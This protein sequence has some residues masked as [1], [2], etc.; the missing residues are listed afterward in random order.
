MVDEPRLR[1]GRGLAALIGESA[2]DS[3]DRDKANAQRRL[4]IEFVRRNPQNPRRD[5][6]E[7]ELEDLAASI[8]EKGILQ[9]IVVRHLNNAPGIYEIIAGERRWR[10]AQ[11]ASMHTIPVVV[12]D[13]TD[14]EALE[15]AIIENVQRADLN[16]LEESEAYA[17][18]IANHNYTQADLAR[19]I[20]KSRSHVANTLRLASLS[21]EIKQ[22][23][24]DGKLSSGHARALVTAQNSAEIANKIVSEGLSVRDAE[25]LAH[26]DPGKTYP[27]KRPKPFDADPDTRAM[28][29]KLQD[30]LG[31]IVDLKHRG[32]SGELKINFKTM[33]QL[34]RVCQ[35]LLK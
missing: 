33:D 7:T 34:D 17:Q 22:L 1:L 12:V 5:F 16:A 4:P 15:I 9:P 13:A 21:E 19:V 10:A 18:L 3:G 32:E 26:A 30:A 20:G 24:R 23:L 27:P 35:K 2:D 29:Q 31:L 14:P 8:R 28:Q 6:N 25:R 11:L